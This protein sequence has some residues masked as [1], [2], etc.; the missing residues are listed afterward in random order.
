MDLFRAYTNHRFSLLPTMIGSV[1]RQLGQFLY[2]WAD[3]GLLKSNL[4]ESGENYWN[5]L[6][7]GKVILGTLS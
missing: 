3:P 1:I 4:M 2:P 5:I 7:W 6:I